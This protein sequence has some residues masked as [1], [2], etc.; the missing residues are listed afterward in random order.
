MNVDLKRLLADL[1]EGLTRLY[2]PRLRGLYLF[3]SYARGTPDTESD[4]DVLIV[5]DRV[6]RYGNE[7]DHTGNLA[8]RLS[9]KYGVTVS[10]VFAPEPDWLSGH[11]PFLSSVRPE[12][13]PA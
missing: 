11:S 10:R 5:L 7:V 2:G 9:L 3:G 4:V 8:S 13:I 12:A 6:E 1:R